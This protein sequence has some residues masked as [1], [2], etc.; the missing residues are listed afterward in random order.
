M[1]PM[2]KIRLRY[3]INELPQAK[4]EVLV[5]GDVVA[6]LP[7]SKV[8]SELAAGELGTVTVQLVAER[9]DSETEC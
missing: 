5:G 6:E 2:G 3:E 9:I 8:T 1:P 4:V 7:A